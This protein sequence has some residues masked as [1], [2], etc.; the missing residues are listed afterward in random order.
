MWNRLPCGTTSL[1][2]APPQLQKN[3]WSDPLESLLEFKIY[4]SIEVL[5]KL[6]RTMM[7]TRILGSHKICFTDDW[8][9]YTVVTA[10]MRGILWFCELRKKLLFQDGM[11]RISF[12]AQTAHFVT[13][14]MFVIT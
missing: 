6:Y 5:E 14:E 10:T 13:T 3:E 7:G 8:Y 4:L 12:G 2:T 9:S 11:G 1:W